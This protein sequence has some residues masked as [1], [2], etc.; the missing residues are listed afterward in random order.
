FAGD[1]G[2]HR[3]QCADAV[4]Q[5]APIAGQDRD[6]ARGDLDDAQ[7]VGAEVAAL[8]AHGCRHQTVAPGFGQ[9]RQ[10]LQRGGQVAEDPLV[11]SRQGHG[12]L[13]RRGSSRGRSS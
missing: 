3:V 13:R 8:L 10:A 2:G 9:E 4:A 11:Q 12:R 5:R 7:A 6:A 1:A